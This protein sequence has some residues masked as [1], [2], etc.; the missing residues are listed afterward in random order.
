MASTSRRKQPLSR[1]TKRDINKVQCWRLQC[2]SVL[3]VGMQASSVVKS[4]GLWMF[5]QLEHESVSRVS[6]FFFLQLTPRMRLFKEQLPVYWMMTIVMSARVTI[7]R[8]WFILLFGSFNLLR[9]EISLKQKSDSQLLRLAAENFAR[10]WA[11]VSAYS[12]S[13]TYTC[14]RVELCPLILL[15]FLVNRSVLRDAQFIY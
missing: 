15:V 2:V 11:L 12:Q 9:A 1:T 5:T 7:V 4:A 14:L 6:T 13:S 3:Y 10:G 8:R